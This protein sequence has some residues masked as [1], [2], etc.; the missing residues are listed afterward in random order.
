[1]YICMYVYLSIFIYEIPN[2]SNSFRLKQQN[3][4]QQQKK[5]KRIARRNLSATQRETKDFG[6]ELAMPTHCLLTL[7]AWLFDFCVT[8]MRCDEF[9]SQFLFMF[10]DYF[11]LLLF[12]NFFVFFSF[13][14]FFR[15]FFL[16][17]TK[18]LFLP[19]AFSLL[20]IE[21]KTYVEFF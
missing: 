15:F 13:L 17:K 20:M 1:M 10:L 12:F 2:I 9:L 21:M 18:T 19:N 11:S 4:K 6:N 3:Q 14:H 16:A 5:R 8:F 7:L